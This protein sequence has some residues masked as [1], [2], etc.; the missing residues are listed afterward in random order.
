M[1]VQATVQN[2]VYSQ[3]TLFFVQTTHSGKIFPVYKP[4]IEHWFKGKDVRGPFNTVT[5]HC[6]TITIQSG[7][8]L[9][10][11]CQTGFLILNGYAQTLQ[12]KFVWTLVMIQLLDAQPA[13][14]LHTSAAPNPTHVFTQVFIVMVILNVNMGKMRILMCARSSIKK[15]R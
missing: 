5:G 8:A 7:K 9:A 13:L 4:S 15:T 10:E 6:Q 3:M 12:I 1:K 11:I 2:L 14:I